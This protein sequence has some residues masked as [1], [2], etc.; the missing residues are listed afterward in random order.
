VPDQSPADIAAKATRYLKKI[1]P[2]SVKVAVQRL[3][4]GEAWLAP[5][6]H[7]ALGAAARAVKRAFGKTPVMVRE[8][9]SIPI[10]ASFSKLLKVPCVLLGI[11]LNDDNLHAPNEKLDLDNFYRGNE[12]AAFL[13]EELGQGS[14]GRHAAKR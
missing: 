12:A 7:P 13:M 6:D 2:P 4:G 8:G 1:A 9:G 14:A 3:H 10:I 11:G 5:T